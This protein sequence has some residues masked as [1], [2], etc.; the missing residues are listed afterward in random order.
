M[1]TAT[2]T[3]PSAPAIRRRPVPWSKLA[4]VTLRQRRGAIIGTSILLGAFAVYLLIMAIIQNNAYA[5]VTACHPAAALKCQQLAQEF[6]RNYWGGNGSALQSGG[7]QTVSSLLFAVPVLLGAFVGA[8]LL[9]R[10]L[11]TG[12][13]RFAW[14]QGAGRTRW[15]RQHAG[16]ARGDC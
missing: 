14:T 13:F 12:T 11:E 9:A 10:E 1:T 16:A 15:A 7:A 8:P 3:A 5:T 6:S 4:W 2:P